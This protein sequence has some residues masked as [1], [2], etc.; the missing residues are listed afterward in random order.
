MSKETTPEKAASI[1]P[2]NQMLND[3]Y[4]VYNFG[5]N[6][7]TFTHPSGERITISALETITLNNGKQRKNETNT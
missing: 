6:Q 7:V 4:F 3:N 2:A 5:T 1:Y